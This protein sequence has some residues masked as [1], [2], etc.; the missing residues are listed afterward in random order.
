MAGVANVQG[1]LKLGKGAMF[2]AYV[3]PQHET[4]KNVTK[5]SVTVQQK[6]GNW[7]GTITSDNPDQQLQTPELSGIFKVIVTASGPKFAETTLTPLPHHPE[8]VGCNSNCAAMIG[9]VATADGTGANY[10]TVW[11]AL[12]SWS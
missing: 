4:E 2:W 11:D 12:C 1:T 6:D 3:S 9:I 5:W 8:D 7:A 10:W